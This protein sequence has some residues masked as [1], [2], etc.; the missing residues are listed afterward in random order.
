MQEAVFYVMIMGLAT[1]FKALGEDDE[2]DFQISYIMYNQLLR[3]QTDILFYTNP[4]EFN[5]IVT[6]PIAS[7]RLYTDMSKVIG[8]YIDVLHGDKDENLQSSTFK[9][10]NRTLINIMKTLPISSQILRLRRLAYEAYD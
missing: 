3:L 9:G 1:L 7:M 10:E 4:D 2:D 6:N 8:D 5:R